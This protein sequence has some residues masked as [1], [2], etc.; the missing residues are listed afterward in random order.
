VSA[1]LP[2]RP[3]R[4]WLGLGL[5]MLL[6]YV[7][8]KLWASHQRGQWGEQL[9]TRAKP[10]DIQMISS[11]TCGI[12][13]Q[14][15]RWFQAE[16]VRFDE[17]FIEDDSACAERFQRLLAPGTPVIVVRGQAQLGFSPERIAQ[18]FNSA[19]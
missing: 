10:G 1:P 13:T 12:C 8:P 15:R 3:W 18:R 9:A 19:P 14:A 2:S 17:C 7:G 6:A 5:L 4:A 11:R 16:A